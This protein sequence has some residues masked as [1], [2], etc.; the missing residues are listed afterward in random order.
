MKTK[1]FLSG[2]LTLASLTLISTA[3][4]AIEKIPADPQA[5]DVLNQTLTALN[6]PNEKERIQALEKLLHKSMLGPG[7]KGLDPSVERFSYKKAVQNA[8]F[9]QLPVN[10]YEVHKGNTSTVGF[11]QTAE[12]GRRDKYFLNKNEGVAGRP[13]PVHI[14]WPANGSAPKVLDFGSL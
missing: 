13:A 10:I 8:K 5:V 9:Y 2:L 6:N 11:K 1:P 4:A 12:T 3:Q 7:G 14:F